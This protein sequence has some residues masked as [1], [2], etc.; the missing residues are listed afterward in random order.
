VALA[1]A[2]AAGCGTSGTAAGTTTATVPTV[3]DFSSVTTHGR[4]HYPPAVISSYMASCTTGRASRL[5]FCGCTLDKLSNDISVKQFTRIGRSGGQL[6][7][8]VRQLINKAATAC[9]GKL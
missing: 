4:Y 5:A 8:R 1:L 6:P 2:A 9:R 3:T 7:P